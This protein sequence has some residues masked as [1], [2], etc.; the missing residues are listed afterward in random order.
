MAEL[1]DLRTFIQS[2]ETV[3]REYEGSWFLALR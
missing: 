1:T 2:Q 3:D